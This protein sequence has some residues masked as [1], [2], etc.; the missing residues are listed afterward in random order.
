MILHCLPRR[1]TSSFSRHFFPLPI[2]KNQSTSANLSPN[3]PRAPFLPIKSPPIGSPY[4]LQKHPRKTP[5]QKAL[6]K[7]AP[8]QNG[9]PQNSPPY[10]RKHKQFA[11]LA[12]VKKTLKAVSLSVNLCVNL[13]VNAFIMGG[14]LFSILL[15]P[16]SYWTT[17][18]S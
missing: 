5:P 3:A 14:A 15:L 13:S 2:C 6:C 4:W 18:K 11:F 1:V 9:P 7:A 16:A 17:E 8:L 12:F 10:A